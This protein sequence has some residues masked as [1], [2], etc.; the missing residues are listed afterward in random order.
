MALIPIFLFFWVYTIVMHNVVAYMDPGII[1]RQ[2]VPP[3]PDTTDTYALANA[4]PP[5]TKTLV[6]NGINVMVKWCNTCNLYR[7]PRAI[8]CGIC[9]NCVHRFDHHCPYVGNCIGLRNYRYFLYFIFG[10][11]FCS[12][13]AFSHSVALISVRVLREGWHD[14]LNTG[15]VFAW[16]IAGLSFIVIGLVGA[17]VSLT[18]FLISNGK[19][20]NENIKNAYTKNPYNRGFS[21]NWFSI[22]C[23]PVYPHFVNPRSKVVINTLENL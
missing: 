18:C 8:H 21:R 6:V 1:P 16:I 3:M 9:D 7:P 22:C 12:C 23:A 2:P 5:V 15:F 11:L 4:A 19:T 14:A 17:L 10:V 13:F 20:T